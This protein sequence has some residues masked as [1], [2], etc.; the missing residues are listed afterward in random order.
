MKITFRRLVWRLIWRMCALGGLAVLAACTTPPQP[1][2]A[3][4]PT[5]APPQA[6]AKERLGSPR[7]RQIALI[8]T[9]ALVP[10]SRDPS[11]P[12]LDPLGAVLSTVGLI[13]FVVTV[14]EVPDQGIT[15]VTIAS[16]LALICLTCS[17]M[18]ARASPVSPTRVTPV[19]TWSPEA[20]F[21]LTESSLALG[22]PQEA[23]K[24]AAVLGANYPGSEWYERAFKLVD[25]NAAGVT[26]S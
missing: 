23:V 19:L 24:Y 13:A 21:R 6:I 14:I 7:L 26:A 18:L 20:L 12:R 16:T 3:P 15:P 17:T 8:A 5:P 11:R 10:E 2:A 25:K 9:L 22:V 4:E 1:P